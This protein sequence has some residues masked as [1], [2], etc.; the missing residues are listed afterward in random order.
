MTLDFDAAY[1]GSRR[2]L[3]AYLAAPIEQRAALVAQLRPRSSDYHLVF[4][5]EFAAQAAEQ[6]YRQLW[7]NAPVWPVPAEPSVEVF[8]AASDSFAAGGREVERFPGGYTE[9]ACWLRKGLIWTAWTI[10]SR[11]RAHLM[12]D[13]LV[14]VE[15]GRWAWFPRPWKVL[16]RPPTPTLWWD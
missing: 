9:I 2:V 15:P 3:L 14:E 12:F 13:G 8:C 10:A 6:G 16:P 1:A 4:D 11:E 7:G 5:P